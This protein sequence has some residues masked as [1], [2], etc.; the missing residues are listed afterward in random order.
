MDIVFCLQGKP[1]ALYPHE[2]QPCVFRS[3][4]GRIGRCNELVQELQFRSAFPEKQEKNRWSMNEAGSVQASPG[5]AIQQRKTSA[6][7]PKS[8]DTAA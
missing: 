4:E 8:E 1:C 2:G 5:E 7:A 6:P 3:S